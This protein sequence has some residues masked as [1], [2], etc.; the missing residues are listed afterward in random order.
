GVACDDDRAEDQCE[1]NRSEKDGERQEHPDEYRDHGSDQ[2]TRVPTFLPT[3]ELVA[4]HVFS[5][6]WP[7]YRRRERR[8]SY[9]ISIL[10]PRSKKNKPAAANSSIAAARVEEE[11][12]R[13]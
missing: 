12:S 3:V 2:E 7:A 13:D 6:P 9:S 5:P 8:D 1:P 11:M 4:L 10:D